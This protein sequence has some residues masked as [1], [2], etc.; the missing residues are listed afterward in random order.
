[1][2]IASITAFNDF[3]PLL[4]V[5]LRLSSLCVQMG[6][7]SQEPVLEA[8]TV[9]EELETVSTHVSANLSRACRRQGC[10]RGTTRTRPLRQ[11]PHHGRIDQ[12]SWKLTFLRV[13]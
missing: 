2:L 10:T 12:V 3:N 9:G 6:Y 4:L 1:M 7:L 8:R 13:Y 11:A 5:V